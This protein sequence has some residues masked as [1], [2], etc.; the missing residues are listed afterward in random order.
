VWV[1]LIGCS[2]RLGSFDTLSFYATFECFRVLVKG[3]PPE[4]KMR[5]AKINVIKLEDLIILG[6]T[7]GMHPPNVVG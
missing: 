3:D 4:A 6:S 2:L 7:F 1:C 5:S